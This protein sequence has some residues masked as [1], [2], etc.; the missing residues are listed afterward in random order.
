MAPPS[1]GSLPRPASPHWF[2]FNP[3]AGQ[4][5]LVQLDLLNN[6]GTTELYIGRGYMPDPE[7]F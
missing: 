1:P 5:V 3:A 2:K 7:S 6:T 4:D